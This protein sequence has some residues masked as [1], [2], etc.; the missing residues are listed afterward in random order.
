MAQI[1]KIISREGDHA[2]ICDGRDHTL[3]YDDGRNIPWG[4]CIDVF[5]KTKVRC[6]GIDTR[7]WTVGEI[8][9]TITC[10]ED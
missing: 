10:E 9:G 7:R 8:I 2:I 4:T 3:L 1:Y 6:P 5:E